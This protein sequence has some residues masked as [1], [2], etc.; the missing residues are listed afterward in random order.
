MKKL[1]NFINESNK[2]D[3]SKKILIKLE[4]GLEF[5]TFLNV[6]DVNESSAIEQIKENLK[7]M[8][9]QTISFIKE[10]MEME[11]LNNDIIEHEKEILE[12][13]VPWSSIFDSDI[14]YDKDKIIDILTS[15]ES[16]ITVHLENQWG[17][18]NQPEVVVVKVEINE[19]LYHDVVNTEKFIINELTKKLQKG[20]DTPWIKIQKKDW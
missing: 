20:L 13:Y 10:N 19:N 17:W 5:E 1:T 16:V 14:V 4:N 7:N 15:D 8:K 3:F 12:L 2:L 11:L 6:K 18:S 9:I